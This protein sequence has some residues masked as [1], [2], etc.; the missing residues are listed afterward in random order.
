MCEGGGIREEE[1]WFPRWR[2][3][4]EKS[5]DGLELWWKGQEREGRG[6]FGH[7]GSGASL[8]VDISG[9]GFEGKRGMLGYFLGYDVATEIVRC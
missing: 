6:C 2:E 4:L 9:V 7:C 1:W 3:W 5:R 8:S